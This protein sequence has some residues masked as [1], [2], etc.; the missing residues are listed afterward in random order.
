LVNGAT[1]YI[2][3]TAWAAG[4]EDPRR[5]T[6]FVVLVKMDK[7]GGPACFPD[8]EAIPRNVVPIFQFLRGF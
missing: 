5:K 7:Y 6:L 3:D 8:D 2:H 4:V 1:G